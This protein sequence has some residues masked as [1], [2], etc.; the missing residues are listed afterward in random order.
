MTL[1]K[2][3]FAQ[4][5]RN[6]VYIR[7]GLNRQT[8]GTNSSEPKQPCPI[9]TGKVKDAIEK[10]SAEK[11]PMT[12]DAPAR[13]LSEEEKRI[14][15]IERLLKRHP[16]DMTLEEIET[17]EIFLEQGMSEDSRKRSEKCRQTAAGL[18]NNIEALRQMMERKGTLAG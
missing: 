3:T 8:K 9:K 4:T 17:A 13:E 14:L 2:K 5:F 16:N 6:S 1:E 7:D 18:H 11:K 12:Q 15:E 10:L